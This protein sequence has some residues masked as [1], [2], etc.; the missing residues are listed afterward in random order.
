MSGP[1]GLTDE[2]KGTRGLWWEKRKALLAFLL[3]RGHT[4][5]IVNKMTKPSEGMQKEFTGVYDHLIIEFGSRNKA[6]YGSQI[7]ETLQLIKRHRGEYIFLCDDPDL[8]FL[9]EELDSID[10]KRWTVW[11]NA[12]RPQAFGKMP[13]N[14]R[15]LDMPFSSIQ[16]SVAENKIECSTDY[17]KTH[18]VYI[19]R[20]DGRKSAFIDLIA[21]GVPFK[22]HGRQA[23]WSELGVKTHESP[24]QPQRA[25]FYARQLGS[26]CIADSKHKILRWRTGRA[27]HAIMAGCPAVFEQTHKAFEQYKIYKTPQHLKQIIFN[28]SESSEARYLDWNRQKMLINQDIAIAEHTAVLSGL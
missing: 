1:I 2:E 23:E 19:G 22:V 3:K 10:E 24:D 16:L 12:V 27:F 18:L 8:P 26:L 7:E 17:Q 11:H 25:N 13:T 5:D 21:Q 15:V 4:I 14:L 6:F 9:W 20:P 28:W